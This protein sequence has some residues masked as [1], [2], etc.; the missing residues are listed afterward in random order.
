MSAIT[1]INK[2]TLELTANFI[3]ITN[4]WEINIETPIAVNISTTRISI[5]S[6][7]T[8]ATNNISTTTATNNLSDTH[9]LNTTIK[10]SSNDIRKPQ[11]KSHPKLEISD[12]TR[13][14]QNPSSQNYL[15]LLAT[16][17]DTLPNIREL[18]QKQSLTNIPPATI[19]EDKSLAAIF[20]FKIKELTKT[21][22]FGGAAF[23]EKP[24]T[25]MYTDDKIDGQFIKLI[26]DSGSAGSIITKQ[27]MDQ[28]DNL[29][30]EINGITIPIKVLVMEATQYQALSSSS[31]KMDNNSLP[32]EIPAIKLK[33][34]L[35]KLRF[36]KAMDKTI[37]IESLYKLFRHK[38]SDHYQLQLDLTMCGHFK[39]ITTPSAPLIEFK[40]EKEKPIWKVEKGKKTKN[41]PEILTKTGKLIMTKTNQQ[42]G[43]EETN[44]TSSTYSLYTYTSLPPSNYRRPKLECVNC[45]KK[46][47]SMDTC[48]DNDK[49]YSTATRFYCHS[50]VWDNQPCLVCETILSDKKMWNNIP[51]HGR[52]CDETCQYTILINDWISKGIPIDNTWK[53]ALMAYVKAEGMTT[54][55][56]LEIK[57]NP[58]SLSEPEYIQTFDIFGNIEDDLKEFHKHYQHLAP[59][60]KEQEQHLEQLNTRLC[61]H[62]LILCNFQYCN[63]CD[64]IYNLPPHMIYTIPEED[65]PISNCT[66]ELESIFN[67]DSNSNNDDDKN[68]GSSSVQYGNKDNSDLD[69]D[70][71]S[72]TFIALSDLTKEQELKWFSDNNKGIISKCVHDTNIGFDLRYPGKDAIKLEPH[73]CICIDFKI[74]LEISATTMVQLASKS[75]L[76]KKGINIRGG[77]IDTRYIENIIAMLQNDLEKAYI[78]KPNEKIAQAIFLPLVKIAQLVSVRKREELK[79]IARGI[80]RF[81]STDRIDISVNMAEEK[82][83]VKIHLVFYCI[84]DYS[85]LSQQSEEHFKAHN[86]N[87]L[88][89]IELNPLPS[90]LICFPI[91]KQFSRQFQNFWNWFLNEH[92]AET[93]TT[94]TTY[95]FD[96]TYFEDNFEK[97][98]N[99]TP[100]E[101]EKE[102][103][104]TASIFDLFLSE[105]EHFTQTVTPKPMVQDPI[106]ANILAALQDIQT[107]LG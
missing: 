83:V 98:N 99:I 70:P 40:K 86:K 103:Y 102:S 31:T 44:L 106:Q 66:S 105:L 11:I 76:A 62:C 36:Q 68:N 85:Y 96:Q 97:K 24:I 43:K 82:I 30:I 26:L 55:K 95:Y 61:Q 27:L 56:L 88:D 57:N 89:F 47:S 38:P 22:L 46:L 12:G 14:T 33:K 4:D 67:P 65:K 21:S 41:L 78:I 79:I 7:S 32:E 6:L 37:T 17:E 2:T 104:Q 69:S 29:P 8:V 15:S 63:E 18:K 73:S 60:R 13:Y 74:A 100:L 52:T 45:S 23:K 91:E 48:C 5:S 1:V 107:A 81:G 50:C 10:L 54:S 34:K 58:L 28:L 59:T 49:K 16:S 35:T 42:T 53:Q 3:I 20:P 75:S 93:Y 51:G 90:C 39:L 9:S 25:V 77:I 84:G 94:Y 92:S 19:M 87:D 64:L 101:T 71:N 72:E 80:Q